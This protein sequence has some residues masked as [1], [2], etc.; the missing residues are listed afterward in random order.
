VEIVHILKGKRLV[1]LV[2]VKRVAIIMYDRNA[3]EKL[4][5]VALAVIMVL[6]VVTVLTLPA[7]AAGQTAVS[8][9]PDSTQVDV[10]NT[11]TF[12]V[13]VESADGGVG[14]HTTNVSLT[15]PSVAEITGVQLAGNPGLSDV[16]RASDNSSVSMSPA[17]MD[18]DDT[19]T[20][21]IASITVEGLTDG[22]TDL[23]LSVSALGDEGGTDYAVFNT[24]DA[25]LTVGSPG[26]M[27]QPPTANFTIDP[28]EPT[29]GEN[30]VLLGATSS[31]PD[32]S[33]TS[34]EWDLDGDGQYDD[35]TAIEQFTTFDSPGEKTVG[36]RVTDSSG[37]TDTVRKNLTVVAPGTANFSVSG[38]SAPASAVQ[39]DTITVNATISNV[40]DLEGTTDAEFVFAG[41]VLFNQ[42]V[43][44]GAGNATDV[45]FDVPTAGVAP[46][47]YEH[48]VQAGNGSQFA[49]ITL[50]QPATFGVSNLS[51]PPNATAGDT[52]T[53]NATISN[54]GD[55]E[56]TTDAEFVFAGDVLLD[57]SVTLGPGNTTDV[58]FDVPVE[59]IP[60][61]TYEHGVQAGNGSQLA[62]ITIQ[63]LADFEVSNLTAPANA[64]VGDTIVVNATV[65]NVGGGQG[66]TVVEFVLGGDALLNQTITLG[67]GNATD[68]SFD[69]LT[70]GVPPDTYEHG[71]QA[72]N[73]S[74]FANITL[75]Q[76]ATFEV[77]NLSAPPNATAGDTITVNATVS[78]VGDIAGTTDAEFVFAGEVLLSETVA[79]DG[80]NS[81]TVSFEV[82]T[83]NVSADIYEHGVQAGDDAVTA[84]ITLQQP[85]T[86][87]V[88]NLT[89]PANAT[90]GDTITVNATVSNVGDIAGTTDAEF[91]F[92]GE[93]LFNESVALD[94]GDSTTVSFEVPT[95]DVPAGTYEHGVQAGN[96]GQFADITLQQP[97]TFEVSNLAAPGS[98]TAGDTIT[99][100][101]TI[102]NVGDLEGTTDA[103][104]VFAGDVLLSQ[105]VTL[106]GGNSVTVSFEVPVEGIPADT[107][108]HGVQAGNDG[109]F[110]N[111]TI[112]T[113]AD[114]EVSNLSA[115]STVTIGDTI[116][117]N[118]TVSNV[119]GGQGTTVV[120]FVFA[121][122][123]LFSQSITL[124]AGNATDVSFDVP[125]T[126]VSSGTYEHGVRA[127]D[128]FPTAQISIN[129]PPTASFLT[130]AEVVAINE[131]VVLD[132]TGSTDSDGTIASY[133]WDLDG[134]GQYD[135]ATGP[136]AGVPFNATGDQTI[137]LRVTDDDGAT[138]IMTVT[139]N[140]TEQSDAVSQ[141]A[142][143]FGVGVALAALIAVILFARRRV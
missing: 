69:V 49:N 127:G 26:A 23:N 117:V 46:G 106:G 11:T 25:T 131:T 57:E 86:F 110:A 13:V 50:Q 72:G 17:L 5:A 79:L 112:Q 140:V 73:G 39:T 18:T 139:V 12:D 88:S 52:I 67:A 21:T 137:G 108:E 34:Y 20:V 85:A 56:G 31:D 121:G 48:G 76:P 28:T 9:S 78:N 29:V 30:V 96:G 142:P 111:I 119:G 84:N 136:T 47:T 87:E 134:D 61:D 141:D 43:T 130:S 63:T 7:G 35:D 19:G 101:A 80:G 126:D 125:T 95:G 128:S 41:D 65:S 89:A 92:A 124:G 70:A 83:A 135:D 81:T 54:V 6:S 60:A 98:A 132:G 122:D 32:G 36:L 64:T 27:N 40:G 42:T 113:L 59:G 37:A 115:P 58:S 116:T 120:E 118:A 104:F 107:Y 103:E 62:D 55:V 22:T 74:Q 75:Q 16:S 90:V 51:A 2:R 123:V 53:V 99:V 129:M 133:E 66:T 33:I 77:S 24:N 82:P 1:G 102:S 71:V 3:R 14:A 4:R 97:A 38:L 10:S 91:V 114:F 94:G 8:L 105:T 100:N 15:D 44:L 143:G 109:Q 93:V 45:S 68:I 138:N